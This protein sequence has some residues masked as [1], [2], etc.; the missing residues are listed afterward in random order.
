MFC[1]FIN[2]SDNYIQR[3]NE[4]GPIKLLQFVDIK[5]ERHL[6]NCSAE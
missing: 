4:K 6:K 3:Q 5:Q 2:N 1:L